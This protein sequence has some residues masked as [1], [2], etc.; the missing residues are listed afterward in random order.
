MDLN[1][2][3]GGARP[4]AVIGVSADKSHV[5]PTASDS[6]LVKKEN[7][8]EILP[9]KPLASGSLAD[10]PV[11]IALAAKRGKKADT[12]AVDQ[13]S[14]ELKQAA[15]EAVES[16]ADPAVVRTKQAVDQVAGD[17]ASTQDAVRK[18][19]QS[20]SETGYALQIFGTH[21]EQ[22][23]HKLVAQYFGQADLL[24]YE[25]LHNGKSWFVVINGPY[26]GRQAAQ[27][28]ISS[29]PESLRRLR[30]WPRNIAS[31]KGD[32]ERYHRIVEASR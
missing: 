16:T 2:S 7:R 12:A 15:E 31:I 23:A 5:S 20:W 27:Q 4:K 26:T 32:I 8:N 30:P 28:S 11:N 3:S 24:F 29:L 14:S 22:R 17:T 10:K 18:R 13:P 19:L 25:T 9:E 6:E 1:G 21:N